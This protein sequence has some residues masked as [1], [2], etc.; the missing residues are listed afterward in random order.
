MRSNFKK[1]GRNETL[2][3]KMKEHRFGVS[4][5]ARQVNINRSTLSHIINDGRDLATSDALRIASAVDSK[6][7]DVFSYLLAR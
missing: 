3:Q 7:E 6:V 4:S 5:L 1:F 2:I